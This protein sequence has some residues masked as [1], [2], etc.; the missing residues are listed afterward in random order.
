MRKVNFLT[1]PLQENSIN[2]SFNFFETFP[3]L[4]PLH[5]LQDSIIVL[6]LVLTLNITRFNLFHLNM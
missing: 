6:Y 3:Y 2:F 1:H 4:V 5:T